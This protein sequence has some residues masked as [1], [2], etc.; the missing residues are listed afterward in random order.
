[1]VRLIVMD[2]PDKPLIQMLFMSLSLILKDIVK[3]VE[4][5]FGAGFELVIEVSLMSSG[6]TIVSVVQKCFNRSLITEE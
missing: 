4:L 5:V 6:S 3:S 2:L 1:M